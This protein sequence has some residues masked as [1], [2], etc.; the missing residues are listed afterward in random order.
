M[1][2]NHLKVYII[3][4]IFATRKIE[5]CAG[6]V[7]C[8]IH[9]ALKGICDFVKKTVLNGQFIYISRKYMFLFQENSS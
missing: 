4:V 1:Y 6:T 7:R 5:D 2:D 8:N 9:I 3:N